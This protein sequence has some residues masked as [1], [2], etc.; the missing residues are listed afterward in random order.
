MVVAEE[1]ANKERE[2]EVEGRI[3]RR[4]A[5]FSTAL[6][7]NPNLTG[8]ALFLWSMDFSLSTTELN[9]SKEGGAEREN[10]LLFSYTLLERVH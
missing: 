6:L 1:K 7:F 3:G 9:N 10:S 2:G 8:F 4:R 5:S